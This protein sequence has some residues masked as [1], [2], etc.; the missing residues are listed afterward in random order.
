VCILVCVSTVRVSI[1]VCLYRPVC[2][3]IQICTGVYVNKHLIKS[4]DECTHMGQ[5]WCVKSCTA[6]TVRALC[7]EFVHVRCWSDF[8]FDFFKICDHRMRAASA[9]LCVFIHC[10]LLRVFVEA[11]MISRCCKF[12]DVSA[13]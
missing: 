6:V 5:M 1:R 7:V 11:T 3:P 8:V 9:V 4:E 12:D 10:A 2:E 13:V